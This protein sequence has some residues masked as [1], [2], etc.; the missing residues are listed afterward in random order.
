MWV[1]YKDSTVH[2]DKVF[3]MD[4]VGLSIIFNSDINS[5]LKKEFIFENIECRDR[6]Y[7]NILACTYTDTKLYK[8]YL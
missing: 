7:D 2:M 1:Q 3:S 5:D 8:L 6:A 4:K